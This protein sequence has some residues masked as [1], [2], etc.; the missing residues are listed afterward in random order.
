[1][2]RVAT[3]VAPSP[4]E[5]RWRR[6]FVQPRRHAFWWFLV[7]LAPALFYWYAP[8]FARGAAELGVSH[9]VFALLI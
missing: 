4:R 1:M 2:T 8:S 3:A 9:A 6:G 5:A 7:L